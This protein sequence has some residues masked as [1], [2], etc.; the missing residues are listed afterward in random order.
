M[1]STYLTGDKQHLMVSRRD[2]WQSWGQVSKHGTDMK[3]AAITNI[4][5]KASSITGLQVAAAPKRS[6]ACFGCN[7]NFKIN[8]LTYIYKQ[9]Q[10]QAKQSFETNQLTSTNP[11]TRQA[12]MNR[13]RTVADSK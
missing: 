6:T 8:Q 2:I 1:Q 3:A 7:Q 10:A 12:G 4:R 13:G 5:D 11:H 9:E